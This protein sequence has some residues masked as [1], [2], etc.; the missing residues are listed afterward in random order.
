MTDNLQAP[1]WDASTPEERWTWVVQ[2]IAAL[3]DCLTTAVE[4]SGKGNLLTDSKLLVLGT[5]IEAQAARLVALE[6]KVDCLVGRFLDVEHDFHLIT[7]EL[8]Q[9]QVISSTGDPAPA[10]EILDDEPALP[11][12][13]AL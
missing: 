6:R 1:A 8:E 13:A 3:Q 9:K 4:Q 2:A 11:A 7:A 12:E 5:K 10:G